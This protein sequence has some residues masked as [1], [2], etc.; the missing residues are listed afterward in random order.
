M[1]EHKRILRS[2]APKIYSQDLVNHLFRHPY[3]KADFLMEELNVHRQTA[4]KYMDEIVALGL[5]SKHRIGRDNYYLNDGLVELL[6][7]A[8]DEASTEGNT[9]PE[10]LG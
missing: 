5:V 1:L 2:A 7:A 8:G 10:G 6:M 3:T 4:S 9:D